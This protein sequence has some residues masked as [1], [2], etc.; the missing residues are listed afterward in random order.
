MGFYQSQSFTWQ[1]STKVSQILTEHGLC[2]TFNLAAP[3]AMYD[4][5]LV[6][7]DLIHEYFYCHYGKGAKTFELMPRKINKTGECVMFPN[8]P[9]WFYDRIMNGVYDAH[10]VYIHDPY[11]LPTHSIQ[12]YPL[13]F[14]SNMDLHVEPKLYAIDSS[15]DDLNPTE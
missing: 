3:E 2:F 14:S 8:A 15:L 7:F 10:F 9:Q 11:E 12:K 13:H 4:V 1:G 5:D 6:T